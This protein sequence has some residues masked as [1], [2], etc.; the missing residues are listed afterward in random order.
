[1]ELAVPVLDLRKQTPSTFD[2]PPSPASVEALAFLTHP[3]LS[4]PPPT[5]A[6]LEV[7]MTEASTENYTLPYTMYLLDALQI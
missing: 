1:M 2:F 5:A 4:T 3:R 6:A 7:C